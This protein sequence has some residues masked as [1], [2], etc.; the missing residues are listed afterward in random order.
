MRVR[1][2]VRPQTSSDWF[3]RLLE[4]VFLSERS[5]AI[6]HDHPEDCS[7]TLGDDRE[8]CKVAIVVVGHVYDIGITSALG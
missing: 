2:L 4:T 8:S 7:F 6:L 5:E 1:E 3:D